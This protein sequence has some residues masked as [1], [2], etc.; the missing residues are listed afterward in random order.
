[1]NVIVRM[2]TMRFHGII[3]TKIIQVIEAALH[4]F[5]KAMTYTVIEELE[6]DYLVTILKKIQ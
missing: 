6:L 3:T 5:F 4:Y 2:D 1:M